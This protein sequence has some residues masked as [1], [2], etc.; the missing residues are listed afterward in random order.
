[1]S[2]TNDNNY[3]KNG[4]DFITA[5][6]G[7]V[8]ANTIGNSTVLFSVSGTWVG[9][10]QVEAVDSGGTW[11]PIQGFL[12]PSSGVF[13]TITSNFQ[14]VVNCGGYSSVRLHATSFTS[15][16]ATVAWSTGLG[17]NI[18]SVFNAN[19]LAFNATMRNTDEP[20]VLGTYHYAVP[21]QLVQASADAATAG[22]LW[23]INP[24]G[25]TKTVRLKYLH[26]TSQIGSALA[27]PTSPRITLERVTFTGVASGATVT[28]CKRKSSDPVSSSLMVTA[29]T[30]LTLAAG[31]V[32]A[33][34]LPIA[35]ATAVGVSSN[36]ADEYRPDVNNRIDL[37]AGEGIVIRQPD[38]GTSSDTRRYALTFI[39]EEF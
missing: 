24:V 32:A 5:N 6:G 21:A 20:T 34:F 36:A 25:A 15:G 38:A 22:R 13:S 17:N 4:S 1:M 9:I 23:L 18:V 19:P 30:G 31:A 3:D 26:F 7:F 16:S 14:V 37:L 10:L 8:A 28:P 27:T 11:F 33:T 39:V 2:I 29:S 35:C 12:L